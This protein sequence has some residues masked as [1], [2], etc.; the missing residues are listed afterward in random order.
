MF[1]IVCWMFGILGRFDAPKNLK[2]AK[3][4]LVAEAISVADH[5]ILYGL[6]RLYRME[7]DDHEEAPPPPPSP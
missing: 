3:T 4:V 5:L 1:I 7:P 2:I 6:G